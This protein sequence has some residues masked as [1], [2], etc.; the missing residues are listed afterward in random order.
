MNNIVEPESGVTIL[1]NIVDNCEK[2]PIL[3]ITLLVCYSLSYLKTSSFLRT[4]G[5]G[6]V[7]GS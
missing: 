4:A 6:K 5:V 3:I 2:M 7:T 1:F